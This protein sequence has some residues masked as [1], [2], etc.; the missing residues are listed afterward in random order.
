MGA[1]RRALFFFGESTVEL[2]LTSNES[3]RLE[4]RELLF[5]L[6]EKSQIREKPVYFCLTMKKSKKK[7]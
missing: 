7:F 3:P 6:L 4:S 5:L 2:L 1:K